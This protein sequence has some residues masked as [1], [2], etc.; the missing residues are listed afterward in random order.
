MP[1]K[2]E[3]DQLTQRD[4]A[5]ALLA[6]RGMARLSEFRRA[7]IAQETV[8]RLAREG[9]ILRLTRGLYQLPDAELDANHTLAEAAKL[10]PKG[11][12]CLLSAAQFHRLTVHTPSAVWMAIVRTARK[13]RIDYPPLR[14][15][16]FSGA[17]FT[18]GVGEH[19]IEGVPVRIYG[20]AKTIVDCFRYRTKIGLDVALEA[21]REGLRQRLCTPDDLYR[22][23]QATRTWAVMRPYLEAMLTDGA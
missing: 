11:V 13:P 3:L 19:E 22:D 16:R 12:I 7:G 20:P 15:V 5:L 17:A 14:I 9:A 2:T 6:D 21:L 10:V 1:V 4:Q 8:A 18:I 23:A